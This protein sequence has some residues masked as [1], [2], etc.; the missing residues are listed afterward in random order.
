M[1]RR[2]V[3]QA[4]TWAPIPAATRNA[5]HTRDILWFTVRLEAQEMKGGIM[6]AEELQNY[7]KLGF[8]LMRLPRKGLKTDIEQT[9]QMVDLFLE[10]GFRYFDTA[11]VYPGSEEATRKA[12]VNRHA[13]E[14]FELATKLNA[15]MLVRN[16]KAAK[17]QFY[18]SLKRTGLEYVD[19]YL[20]HGLMG[21]NYRSYDRY[22]IW[23]Y[24]SELKS[25]GL[26]RQAGF[27]FHGGPELLEEILN[28]HPEMDFVQLQINY[29]D[30][31]S[32]RIAS[33]A[34]YE[35]ARAHG[36]PV[37]IME[38][39]KGGSLAKPPRAVRELFDQADPSASYAS[40]AIRFAASLE[41]VL[42]VLS[43]MSD[44][45]QMQD[46]VS[47]M[48]D[49]RPLDAQERAVIAQA[50]RIMGKESG[51][52]CTA[53][54]Y[55]TKGCPKQ[56]PIPEIFAAANLR[57][58]QGDAGGFRT[59]Y[60]ELA[61]KGNVAD[62]CIACGQCERACPQHIDVIHQLELCAAGA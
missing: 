52:P 26:V 62:A 13:R 5:R 16:E 23:E 2:S 24:V 30:W 20:L 55:C 21:Q 32:N 50:Q 28:V 48:R 56:I 45:A 44:L 22:H 29:A 51:I 11:Y 47:Y 60:A 59:A 37:I 15:W 41:G 25:K 14:E 4:R 57:Y 27:S 34:N 53:C 39:V 3:T 36:K 46:N 12:L 38:P 17:K 6:D 42:T 7:P 19:Y 18:T 9:K 61:A 33:R 31:E 10:S 54:H 8:G 1:P 35:V 58:Q 49:F 43:G 40:W